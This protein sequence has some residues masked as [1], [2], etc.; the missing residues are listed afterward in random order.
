MHTSQESSIG[1]R[2]A[3]LCTHVRVQSDG[4]LNDSNKCEC[5]AKGFADPCTH[6]GC[7]GGH[8]PVCALVAPRF[9]LGPVAT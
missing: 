8:K 3:R 4:T 9:L 6:V 5:G 2:D 1:G 7:I